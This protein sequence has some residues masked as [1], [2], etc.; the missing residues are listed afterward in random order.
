MRHSVIPKEIGN[1]YIAVKY[2]EI[3]TETKASK[4]IYSYQLFYP[5]HFRGK[6]T[7]LS[8]IRSSK[9]I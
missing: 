1:A 2:I 9:S 5:P 4:Q 8:T 3:G 6:R 7:C